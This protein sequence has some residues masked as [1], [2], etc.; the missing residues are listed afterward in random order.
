MV[1]SID[2]EKVVNF[3]AFGYPADKIASILM[4]QVSEV[5]KLMKDAESEFCKH[6]QKGVHTADYV[7]D[8]KLFEMSQGGDLKALEEFE[9]R[10]KQ[11]K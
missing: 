2:L 11:R 9:Y 8:M 5:E 1:G 3:G 7:I 4:I 6:Y 10:K